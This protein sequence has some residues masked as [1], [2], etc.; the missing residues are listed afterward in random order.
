[1]PS[2]SSTTALRFRMKRNSFRSMSRLR[3]CR[4][5]SGS[6]S[7]SIPSWQ[8]TWY[9]SVLR[10]L[11]WVS[12][13]TSA[14]WPAQEDWLTKSTAT[15]PPFFWIWAFALSLRVICIKSPPPSQGLLL[16]APSQ[17]LTAT[18]RAGEAA[19]IALS[20]STAM[21]WT[22]S[23]RPTRA[24]ISRVKNSSTA[25]SRLWNATSRNRGR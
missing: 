21:G 16:E 9:G 8:M 14:E 12:T 10:R 6:T 11:M 5:N 13:D 17:D 19:S 22:N 18:W 24:T 20:V 25:P 7:S 4:A 1:M 2:E 23:R 15:L 3:V